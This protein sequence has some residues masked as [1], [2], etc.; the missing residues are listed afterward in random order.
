MASWLIDD[1]VNSWEFVQEGR[2]IFFFCLNL[3]NILQH[4]F[5]ND[6]LLT[7]DDETSTLIEFARKKL[8]FN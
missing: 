2:G 5:V 7:S 3:I 1:W 4:N 6:Q 8:K